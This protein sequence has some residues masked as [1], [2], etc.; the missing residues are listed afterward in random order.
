[1]IVRPKGLIGDLHGMWEEFEL[2]V[3]WMLAQG[4]RYEDIWILGDLLDRGEDS[5]RCV[6]FARENGINSVMGNHEN[7]ILAR[8]E[9]HIEGKKTRLNE[10]KDKTISQLSQADVDWLKALPKLHVFDDLRLILVHGGYYH[11]KEVWQQPLNVIRAQL[12]NVDGRLNSKWWGQQSEDFYGFTELELEAQGWHRWYK[13]YDHPYDIAFGHSVFSAPFI[14]KNPNSG[15]C[16]G[17]DQG[18]VFGG[19]LT[20]MIYYGKDDY[21]IKQIQSKRVYC[22]DMFK[23]FPRDDE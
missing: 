12:I 3:A 20:G 2:L 11:G 22:R 21:R 1:M 4:L 10:D 5:G 13:L 7:S 23:Q 17:L 6:R 16:F 9:R 18:G 19:N 15:T 8:W 14:H